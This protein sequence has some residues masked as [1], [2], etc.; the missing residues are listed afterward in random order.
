MVVA[1]LFVGLTSLEFPELLTLTD[2]ASN[3][4]ALVGSTPSAPHIAKMEKLRPA[5]EAIHLR[6]GKEFFEVWNRFELRD[7]PHSLHFSSDYIDFLCVY[8]T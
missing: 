2:N 6:L 7:I 3:D 1:F 4:F 8:R 5:P